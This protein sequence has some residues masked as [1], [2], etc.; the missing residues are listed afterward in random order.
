MTN[1]DLA[2]DPDAQA[3]ADE[4]DRLDGLYVA[5]LE[6]G[7]PKRLGDIQ[8][9][10]AGHLV[11]GGLIDEAVDVLLGARDSYQDLP[12]VDATEAI[13]AAAYLATTVHDW[14]TAQGAFEVAVEEWE[15]HGNPHA[16]AGA[17]LGLGAA[18]TQ[19]GDYAL[20][21]RELDTAL[22]AYRKLGLV[23]AIIETRIN[24]ANVYRK[25]GRHDMAENEY[26]SVRTELPIG[27]TECAACTAN[28]AALLA[29]CQ[30][31][32]EA[33]R[34]FE[35]ARRQFLALGEADSAAGCA[36]ALAHLAMTEG[37][38]DSAIRR[39]VAVREQFAADG[40]L[41]KVAECDYNLANFYS[42]IE[43][44]DA[45]DAA[46][47]AALAGLAATG[48]EYQI[49]NLS[50]NRVKRFLTQASQSGEDQDRLVAK[51]LDCAVSSLIAVE[52]QRLQFPDAVRRQAWT[53]MYAERLVTTFD[54]VERFGSPDLLADLIESAVN[55][56][57]Y[58][59]D[60]DP[61]DGPVP[62]D[63][64]PAAPSDPDDGGDA[65]TL[66]TAARLITA[67]LPMSPPPALWLSVPGRK[68]LAQQRGLIASSMPQLCG[69]MEQVPL[70][71]LW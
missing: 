65:F 9:D 36:A 4:L 34:E 49:A 64:Q 15:A 67:A 17:R 27:S 41:G 37:D 11:Q 2:D 6:S 22:A 60:V 10:I 48:S 57:V 35:E 25:T 55:A 21:E 12:T 42:A 38:P 19:L 13:G 5:A 52:H 43:D 8:V 58:N 32:A 1:D 24:L 63:D 3:W 68:V 14:A 7:D 70:V 69:L 39:T 71:A 20:A 59:A 50:W 23:A 30:R 45:A 56:G 53:Q 26:R 18:S 29:E 54:L 33:R 40:L 47:E 31:N 16:A 28:L 44:F 62:F 46:Y 66:G 51:A 61:S